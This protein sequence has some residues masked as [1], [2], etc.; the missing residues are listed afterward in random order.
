M[1]FD[2]VL[3]APGDVALFD[4]Y[5][6]HRSDANATSAPRRAAYL[7]YNKVR[8]SSLLRLRQLLL[9]LLKQKVLLQLQVLLKLQLLLKLQQLL[10]RPLSLNLEPRAYDKR[11]RRATCTPRITRRRARSGRRAAAAPSRST[12][13]SRATSCAERAAARRGGGGDCETARVCGAPLPPKCA[14]GCGGARAGNVGGVWGGS[15]RSSPV[16]WRAAAR[17]AGPP[18]PL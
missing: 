17:V 15:I 2:D 8:D 3:V 10:N 16:D 11:P 18:G 7:T 13:T 5:L 1:A 4:S 14:R 6:P 9:I 12:T